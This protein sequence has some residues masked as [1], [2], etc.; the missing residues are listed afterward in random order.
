MKEGLVPGARLADDCFHCAICERIVEMR[1]N[2][3]PGPDAV[4]PP[5]CNWCERDYSRG[6]GKPS[7]GAFRDRRE[8]MRGFALAEALLTTANRQQ[9]QWRKRYAA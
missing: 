4:I 9:W 1:W 2:R 3:Y 5:L 7:H 8:V 6:I